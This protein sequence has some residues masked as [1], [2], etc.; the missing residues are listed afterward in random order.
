MDNSHRHN[1]I[2]HYSWAFVLPALIGAT[3]IT[4]QL[5]DTGFIWY[6][7][8]WSVY[9]AGGAHYGPLSI[10]GVIKRIY[11]DDPANMPL[12]YI[13][14]SL[15]GRLVGWHAPAI[16]R[17]SSLY[18]SLLGIAFVYRLASKT[19]TNRIAIISA[20]L[21]SFSAY[22]IY[23]NHELRGYTLNV[24]WSV[25]AMLA[26]WH[27]I[28]RPKSK[29]WNYALITLVVGLGLYTNY[30]AILLLIPAA[31]YHLTVKPKDSHW[32]KIS[33]AAIIG[34]LLFI[35]W[36]MTAFFNGMSIIAD[37]DHLHLGLKIYTDVIYAISN[38]L[39]L[40]S[41]PI[42]IGFAL[43]W[44]S[45]SLLF[46]S[47]IALIGLTLLVLI[48]MRLK[49]VTQI[50]YTLVIW[51]ALF[52]ILGAGV[53]W[54]SR[55]HRLLPAAF[56]ALW[57][58]MGVYSSFT[59]GYRESLTSVEHNAFFRMN[60]PFEIFAKDIRD[61][62]QT[63]DVVFFHF[64]Q[65]WWMME[66]TWDYY[67]HDLSI[68]TT[69]I[70]AVD[71]ENLVDYRNQ[72]RAMIHPAGRAWVG[73]GKFFNPTERF[74]ELEQVLDD[75]G[76]AICEE[77]YDGDQMHV[78]LYARSPL[79]CSLGHGQPKQ[80]LMDFTYNDSI[81][82]VAGVEVQDIQEDELGVIIGFVVEE[83][84][85]IETFSVGMH[86]LAAN[87]DVA[88]QTDFALPT[89]TQSCEMVFIPVGSLEPAEYTLGIAIYDWRTGERLQGKQLINNTLGD[90]LPLEQ[91][92]IH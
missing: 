68:P 40:L 53:D 51:P 88:A 46:Y 81:I 39:I 92:A 15:W 23:Y 17:I 75:E 10:F 13:L 90:W 2:G 73:Y 83:G 71:S 44:R 36:A 25:M 5:L 22:L 58:A 31:V 26:Y 67:T 74:T 42:L 61:N 8:Y 16:L 33:L 24:L 21:T 27:A 14:L 60:V 7:E 89:T 76:F 77:R 11:V 52:I 47:V 78:D 66:N 20:Y 19:T 80:N 34:G 28:S 9:S 30:L 62:T 49:F 29:I 63:G 59:A 85:P 6:D 86:L 84:I 18:A 72:I 56:I 12:Y 57:I 87:G 48:D 1:R 65:A 41:I 3:W 35:P 69:I 79:C 37:F 64:P 55:Y 45:R 38:G 54:L 4:A 70:D 91:V 50:R 32:W 82:S 43:A